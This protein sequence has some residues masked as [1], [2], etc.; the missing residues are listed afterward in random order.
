M[1]RRALLCLVM[2]APPG[3]RCEII[4]RIAVVVGR[5]VITA[6]EVT[7]EVRLT[8]FL[9]QTKL[10]LSMDAKRK[11][12]ERLIDQRLIRRE[13]QLTR[14]PTPPASEADKLLAQYRSAHFPTQAAFEQALRQYGIDQEDLK[15]HLLW[16]LTAMRFIEMRFRPGIQ[17]TDEEVGREIERRLS[18]KGNTPQQAAALDDDR[19][20]IREELIEQRVD[21]QVDRWLKSA[22][23]GTTIEIREEALR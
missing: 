5:G 23:E 20:Q 4:D 11:A 17:V 9:N 19:T 1:T 16:Q 14:Y 2:L 6:S 8:D 18:A 10:D 3:A 21:Q 22:R 15:A 7:R 12:V 13:L